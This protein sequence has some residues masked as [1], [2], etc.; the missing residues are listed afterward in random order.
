MP[1][2][3]LP[4]W[5]INSSIRNEPLSREPQ[6]QRDK[7]RAIESSTERAPGIR[8]GPRV[9]EGAW[10]FLILGE[11]VFVCTILLQYPTGKKHL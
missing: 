2:H 7:E 10:S 9:S 1:V 5:I 11:G 3:P 4:Q 8:N 6:S